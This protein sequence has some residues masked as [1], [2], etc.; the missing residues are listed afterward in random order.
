MEKDRDFGLLPARS[1]ARHS[2]LA[3]SRVT[4]FTPEEEAAPTRRGLAQAVRGAELRST[5]RNALPVL[6]LGVGAH[7]LSLGPV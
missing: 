1:A 5:Q 3:E 4:P 6:Q 7:S 2:L